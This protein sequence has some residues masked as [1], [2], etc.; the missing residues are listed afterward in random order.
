M[1]G[2]LENSY[3]YDIPAWQVIKPRIPVTLELAILALL[4]AV[5]LGYQSVC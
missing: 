5:L 1:R 4:V 2:E 3:R